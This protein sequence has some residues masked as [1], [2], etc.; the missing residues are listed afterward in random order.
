MTRGSS[1]IDTG[2]YFAA[3][4]GGRPRRGRLRPSFCSMALR[5]VSTS[6]A[7]T[8]RAVSN[9]N[10]LGFFIS[11]ALPAAGAAGAD[12]ARH[13]ASLPHGEDHDEHP[14][15]RLADEPGPLLRRAGVTRIRRDQRVGVVECSDGLLEGDSMLDT[16]R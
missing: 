4:L 13:A 10:A 11:L 8:R 5:A 16:V 14:V 15:V 12:E 9:G 6:R 7:V 2:L 3:P 1:R